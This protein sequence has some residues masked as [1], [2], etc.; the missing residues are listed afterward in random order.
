MAYKH[1]V[2]VREVPTSIIPAVNSMAGL[3]VIFGTAPVH[4]AT[5]PAPANKPVLCHSY[6]EAVAA[7]GYS[8]NWH[9]YT[10]CE[11]IYS[12]FALFAVGPVVLVNVLDIAVHKTTVIATNKNMVDGVI[13]L[14]DPVILTS[15]SV[16]LTQEG[17]NLVRGID[18]EALY[19]DKEQLV[20]TPLDG[21]QVTSDKTS[22]Y[23]K[24][25]KLDPAAIGS[26][27]II[28]GIDTVS[29]AVEGLEC[30][31]Q[32]FPLYGLV[33]GMV[34]APGWS[35]YPEVAAVMSAKS[36]NING[37]FTAI[38]LVDV[39]TDKVQKYTDVP[40]WKNQNNYTGTNQVVCWPKVRMGEK[41]Y[42]LSTQLMAVMGT[43]DAS[44]DDVPYESPSNK[45]LQANGACLADGAEVV[46]GPE[47][48][49]YLNSQGLVTALNFMGGWKVWGNHTGCYPTNTDPKDAFI[50]IRRMNNWLA[51]TFIQTYWAK[52][53]K[54][55]T[56]R[57]IDTVVDSENI[58]LNGLMARGFILGGRV[59]F[60]K[61]ENPVTDLMDGI[62]RF[63]TYWT[64]PTP[65]RVIDNVIEYDPSYFSTLFA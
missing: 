44:N 52:V 28:G 15:L 30:L 41:T 2:Y 19:N 25:D 39:P 11:A 61:E 65:A 9:D 32:V 23:V 43:V 58:R 31:N 22:L 59:E 17:Q 51:Q 55:I 62:M 50:C 37:H 48:A 12:Q 45:N 36:G 16:Q 34:L 38:S 40:I 46:L 33:P 54:P 57:L 56:R 53:D 20:I 1:G 42:C 27:E 49:T 63:H 10:L 8:D 26:D 4:L 6:A 64:P 47:Q 18:Y 3:P 60:V 24:Y 14:L 29:G 13:T 7:F 21:G 5:T 35:Q